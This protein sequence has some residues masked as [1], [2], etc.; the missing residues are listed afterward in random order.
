MA[1][2]H[3]ASQEGIRLMT[4]KNGLMWKTNSERMRSPE[5]VIFW[6]DFTWHVWLPHKK[7][8][9]IEIFKV[10]QLLESP[11]WEQPQTSYII[12]LRYDCWNK[13]FQLFFRNTVGDE[14]DV[15]SSGRLFHRETREESCLWP[16]PLPNFKLMLIASFKRGRRVRRG[17]VSYAG[18]NSAL[19]I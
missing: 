11:W 4:L 14:A 1:P 6:S 16:G 12:M 19:C 13:C 17:E 9:H 7:T 18:R 3:E 5:N 10:A 15:M 2:K 8:H